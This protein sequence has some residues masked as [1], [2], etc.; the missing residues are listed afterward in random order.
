MAP[1]LKAID[2]IHV[3][4]ADRQ[5]ASVWYETVLGLKPLPELEFWAADGGPL[6]VADRTGSIHIALFEESAAECRSTIALSVDASRFLSWKEH[7]S[8]TLGHN[9]NAVDHVVSWSLYFTDPDANPYEITSY[10][11]EAIRDAFGFL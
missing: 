4:V 3:F 5:T 7:L 10:E 2:H 6:T 1:Q 11:Y 9:V 8:K